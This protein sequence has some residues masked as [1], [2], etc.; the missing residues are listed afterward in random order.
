MRVLLIGGGGREHAL[1]WKLKKDDPELEL[2]AAPGNPGIA[3]LAACYPLLASRTQDL[4][5]LAALAHAEHVDLTVV[6]P[7][8]PLAAGIVDHF[9][10]SGLRIFGPS[11]SAARIESSKRFAK[12]LMFEAGVPTARASWHS[13]VEPAKRAARDFGAPVVIKA[14]GLAGGKGVVVC[15]SLEEADV[16]IEA[17]LR[18]R[19]HG[20]SGNEILV[21]E[22]MYGE[23]LSVFAIADGDNSLLMLPSQDHKRLLPGDEG[24]N[25]GGMGAY[26]PVQIAD[27]ALMKRIADEIVDPTI[28]SLGEHGSAFHGLLYCG[29]MVTPGGPKVVEY[30]CR[31]GDPETEAVLPLMD[32]SL[33]DLMLH[34]TEFG[35]LSEAMSPKFASRASVTTVVAAPGYPGSPTL[36]A[37]ITLPAAEQDVLVFHSGTARA[38]DGALITAGG[39]VV[40]VTAVADSIEEAQERSR[41]TAEHVTFPGRQFRPDIGWREIRRRAGVA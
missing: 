38:P 25:T 13:T 26:A 28:V 40:A 23:E 36:G 20:D 29:I 21:E 14:S 35:G 8:A 2:L 7:E 3:Q 5:A 17:M 4:A 6:G 39:R 18:D 10:Q 24:P 33:L 32:S 27:A 1:A 30:N 9:R 19:I 12:E 16:A 11:Q 15:N 41:L 34:S 31:F 37:P 22:F